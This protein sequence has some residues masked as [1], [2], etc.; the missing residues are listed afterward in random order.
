MFPLFDQ[1]F[2]LPIAPHRVGEMIVKIGK[3]AGVVVNKADGK[4]AAPTTCGGP[5]ARDGR[6]D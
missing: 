2:N 1:R 5:T 4:F 6:N 3:K